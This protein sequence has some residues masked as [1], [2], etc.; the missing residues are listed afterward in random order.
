MPVNKNLLYYLLST[1]CTG[2]ITTGGRTFGG[3]G[4]YTYQNKKKIKNGK[5]LAAASLFSY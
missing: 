1:K 4:D 5:I 2:C 3:G